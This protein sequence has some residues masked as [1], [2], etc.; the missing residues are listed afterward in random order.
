M[1]FTRPNILLSQG[2]TC[3]TLI[4]LIAV[5]VACSEG[6]ETSGS[7]G[8]P[9]GTGALGPSV[10]TAANTSGSGT[11]GTN[12]ATSTTSGAGGSDAQGNSQ[13]GSQGQDGSQGQGGTIG[14]SSGL[15]GSPTTAATSADAGGAGGTGQIDQGGNGGSVASGGT[16]STSTSGAGGDCVLESVVCEGFE[17]YAPGAPPEGQWTASS[18]GAGAIVI[19]TTR[20]FSGTQSLHVTG[21]LNADHANISMPI[22]TQSEVLHVRFMMY[23]VSYPATSGVHTRLARIGI[24]SAANGAPYSAYAL[25]TYNGTA[26]EKVNSIYLRDTGTHMDDPDLTNRWVCWEFGIDKS[27]GEGNVEVHLRVDGRD[28]P[29]SPAGSSSHG[30]TSDSWDPI[31]FELFMLG[32]DGFQNDEQRADFWIDDLRVTPE[33]VGCPEM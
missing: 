5:S 15:G 10:S 7:K 16:A 18:R 3:A 25:A 30:M 17:G 11:P 23:T 12:N 26:I 1:T 2:A 21:R 33:R 27:G 31:A 8:G 32:L 20:A 4:G 14:G 6:Q 13:G 24:T 19:D 29:L 28:L 22:D 9:T